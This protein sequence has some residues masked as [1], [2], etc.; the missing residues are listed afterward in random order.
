MSFFDTVPLDEIAHVKWFL[1]A[2]E[3]T[4][5]GEHDSMPHKLDPWNSVLL[6]DVDKQTNSDDCGVFV[7]LN[8]YIMATTGEIQYLEYPSSDELGV[9]I[10]LHILESLLQ[11]ALTSIDDILLIIYKMIIKKPEQNVVSQTMITIP[12]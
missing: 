9:K 3:R 8:S 7:C 4:L 10:R 2:Y 6:K 5:P 12:T 11:S 1:A